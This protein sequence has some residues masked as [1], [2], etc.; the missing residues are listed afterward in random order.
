MTTTA[1]TTGATVSDGT[2]HAAT[3]RTGDIGRHEIAAYAEAAKRG[4]V[5]PACM[6]LVAAR[7]RGAWADRASMAL[8]VGPACRADALEMA[9]A[10]MPRAVEPR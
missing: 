6:R 4:D 8:V 3:R 9:C 5:L 7:V 2:L 1:A 10:F